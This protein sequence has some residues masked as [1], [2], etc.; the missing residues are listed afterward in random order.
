MLV[1]VFPK[2]HKWKSTSLKLNMELSSVCLNLL[3]SVL[4]AVNLPP[5][6]DHKN[7]PA[8]KFGID[9]FCELLLLNTE[10]AESLLGLI[11]VSYECTQ[12]AS[13]IDELKT[14]DNIL[15]Q[16]VSLLN[17]L[18]EVPDELTG[19]LSTNKKYQTVVQSL[20]YSYL[21]KSISNQ[22]N[23]MSTS[24]IIQSTSSITGKD[25]TTKNELIDK[26]NQ[27]IIQLNLMMSQTESALSRTLLNGVEDKNDMNWFYLLTK[28][29]I[30]KPN[31]ILDCL[32]FSIFKKISQFTP[33]LFGS[34]IG[35]YTAQI[36][37][38]ILKKLD[39]RSDGQ[40]VKTICEFLCSL[41]E[42]QPGFF[43]IL[44]DLRIEYEN[45]NEKFV[46][47]ERSVLKSIFTL[48]GELNKKVNQ[49]IT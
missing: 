43:Q 16:S 1:S 45:S 24:A 48:L 35:M 23:T 17:R 25:L 11:N 22:G 28:I 18:I 12:D 8:G 21:I 13:Y 9:Q 15:V 14:L 30:Y 29:I 7:Q 41:V 37:T 2:L 34:L 36:H 40:I 46:D 19:D 38:I 20:L 27:L 39:S 6:S 4:N 5:L 10:C 32:L 31:R 33:R 44:V 47:S 26:N 49:K 42:N 3:H